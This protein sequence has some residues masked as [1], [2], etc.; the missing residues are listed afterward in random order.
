V[1][2]NA[3][4]KC[5]RGVRDTR[6]PASRIRCWVLEPEAKEELEAAGCF[7]AVGEVAVVAFA[8]TGAGADSTGT[9]EL[10]A[11][12]SVCGGAGMIGAG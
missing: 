4:A 9:S 8:E 2:W 6:G 11:A 5:R 1:V 7:A 3:W 12:G 10:I